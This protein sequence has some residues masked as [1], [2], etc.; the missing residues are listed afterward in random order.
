MMPM[1]SAMG[2]PAQVYYQTEH[3]LRQ[4]DVTRKV[5]RPEDLMLDQPPKAIMT[6]G[7]SNIRTSFNGVNITVPNL[8]IVRI[9]GQC[10]IVPTRRGEVRLERMT[11][12]PVRIDNTRVYYNT[13]YGS[14]QPPACISSD[15][16]T[17]EGNPS[18][19]CSECPFNAWGSAVGGR[20]K[21]CQQRMRLLV[22]WGNLLLP[23]VVSL[24]RTSVEPAEQLL[25]EL[26]TE[27]VLYHE[28]LMSL[29]FEQA[30]N[31]V[32]IQYPR[33]TLRSVRDLTPEEIEVPRKWHDYFQA[34]GRN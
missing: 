23:L 4:Q 31:G 13:P 3:S 30:T 6:V 21:A 7:G 29:E 10:Y 19:A 5:P 2:A 15:G 12:V 11:I 9:S 32:G 28:T 16:I 18:G 26:A 25:F 17:G 20:G 8:P 33:P 24:P 14:K 22:L 27:D 1:T 34:Q